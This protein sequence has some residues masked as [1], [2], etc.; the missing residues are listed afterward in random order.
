VKK[1]NNQID[2]ACNI[3]EK[4]RYWSAAMTVIIKG[5]EY[6]NQLGLTDIPMRPLQDFLQGVLA[7]MRG[8]VKESNVDMGQA[9]NIST[10]FQ[11]FLSEKLARH[12]LITNR[13]LTGPGKPAVGAIKVLNDMSKL[14][15]LH[16]QLGRE[17]HIIRIS[18]M[19]LGNWLKA[20]KPAPIPHYAFYKALEDTFKFTKNSSFLGS[21]TEYRSLVREYILQLD[22]NNFPDL[23]K[24]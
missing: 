1:L 6:A 10:L 14:D 5:A 20:Y 17:D 18:N 19:A 24:E 12:T 16:V 23:W 22:G 15:G 13:V 2:H 3:G 21:G 11:Q 7:R 8:A 9:G 4:E